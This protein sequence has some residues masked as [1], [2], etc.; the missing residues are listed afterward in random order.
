MDS[1]EKKIGH[2]FRDRALLT[3]AL[4][5]SSYANEN[6]GRGECNERLEFLGDSVL[7]MVVADALF[8]RFPELPEGR[9]TRLR[10][11]LVCEESLHRVAS[12]LGLGEYVRLGRGEEHT[13]GRRRTSILAD[14]VEAVIAAMYLDGGLETAKAFIER[15]ILSALDGAGPVMRV[16]DCKTELQEL[17]QK[18]SGQSLSYELLGESGPDHDKTFTSQVSLNGRPVG[19]GSG[20]TKKEAEQAAARAALEALKA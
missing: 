20:R 14:A 5:H 17:V 13:G 15:Q 4:T 11:Q 12:E 2:S 18:K 6:R 9:M 7:G 10:A 3:T 1:L 8:R 16:E 19:S